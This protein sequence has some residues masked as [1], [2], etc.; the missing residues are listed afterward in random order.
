MS[1]KKTN[2][3]DLGFMDARIKLIDIAAFL[4]RIDRHDQSDDYRVAALKEALP[5]LLSA[6]TG[7]AARVLNLLSDQST[8]PVSESKIQGAFGAPSPEQ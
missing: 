8:E 1:E 4:D 5:E 7:R 6:E 3:V 2:L